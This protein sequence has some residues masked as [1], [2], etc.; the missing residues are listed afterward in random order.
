VSNTNFDRVATLTLQNHASEIFD[1]I[2]SNNALCYLL[3]KKGNIKPVG[4]GRSFTHPLYYLINSSFKSYGKL[5][6]I[7]TPIMDD[8]TRAD[9]PIKIVA[10]SLVM[11]TV[12]E[13]QNAGNKEKLLDYAE[14]VRMAAE[15]SM[16]EVLGEQVWKDGSV[17]N[18]F[19]GL[20]NLI[21]DNPSAQTD[22]GGISAVDYS[23]WRNQ[24]YTTEISAFN[25]SEAGLTQMNALLNNCTFGR[26]GPRA[27]LTTKKIYGLYE[28]GLTPQI[29]YT[30]TELADAG[31]LNL[32]YATMPV[33]FDDNCPA[34]HMYY[35]DTDSLWLQVLK[36]GNMK[37]IPFQQAHNQLSKTALM[38]LFGNLTT[39]SRRTQGVI[40]QITG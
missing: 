11:S 2:T 1:N 33:L 32:K 7:D 35:I 12:E 19:D 3:K 20:Q 30:D 28:I 16:T 4:G 15:L 21:S 18:D 13:A 27:I 9:F 36:Q 22:V 17:A 40:T 39:G 14:E 34:E 23:Y 38:Y 5:D 37:V 25:T 26:K 31:F 29:R 6:V 8:I 10:G 24:T